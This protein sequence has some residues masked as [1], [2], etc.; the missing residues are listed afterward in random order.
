[1]SKSIKISPKHGLNPSI[2]TCFWCG[3][4]KNEII[5][6]GRIKDDAEMPMHA[7]FDYEPCDECKENM[8]KGIALIG[9]SETPLPDNRPE[10]QKGVYPTGTWCVVTDDFIKRNIE[11]DMAET[12]LEKRKCF[13]PDDFVKEIIEASKRVG[14]N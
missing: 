7:V 1:M 3:K 14:D 6:A 2:S 13:V 8:A 10:I 12:V 9:A 4:D 5:L 11:P